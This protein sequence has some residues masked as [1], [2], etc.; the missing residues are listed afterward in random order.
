[1]IVTIQ[2]IQ[3]KTEPDPLLGVC[4]ANMRGREPN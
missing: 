2:V 4:G 1:M 3:I